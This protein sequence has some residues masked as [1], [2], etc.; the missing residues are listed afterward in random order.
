M[1]DWADLEN[2][3]ATFEEIEEALAR[4]VA[5]G[6]LEKQIVIVN[7]EAKATYRRSGR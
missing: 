1:P 4:L 6:L 2:Y 7:G 5:K 3:P